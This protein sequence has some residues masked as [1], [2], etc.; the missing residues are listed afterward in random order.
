[1][2]DAALIE[3]RSGTDRRHQDDD[4]R[5]AAELLKETQRMAIRNKKL[6]AISLQSAGGHDID[7]C[8]SEE[9]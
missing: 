4:R 3:Q 5:R 7:V 9:S 8:D 2:V 1:V 6:G